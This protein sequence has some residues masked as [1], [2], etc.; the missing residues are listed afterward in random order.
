MC[1]KAFPGILTVGI[2]IQPSSTDIL[3]SAIVLTMLYR[4]Y[5]RYALPRS[6]RLYALFRAQL[7]SVFNVPY[8]AVKR[9]CSR[10]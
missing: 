10:D 7:L 5:D 9:C 3:L 4:Q 6:L 1:F 8:T 2:V